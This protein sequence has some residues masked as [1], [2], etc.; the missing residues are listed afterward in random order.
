[1]DRKK[2]NQEEEDLLL[3]LLKEYEDRQLEEQPEGELLPSEDFCQR[4]EKMIEDPSSWRKHMREDRRKLRLIQTQ[5]VLALATMAMVLFLSV[6]QHVGVIRTSA[7]IPNF[8]LMQPDESDDTLVLRP[9]PDAEPIVSPVPKKDEALPEL[10]LG[11]LPSD[12]VYDSSFHPV[13]ENQRERYISQSGEA[14]IYSSI[15]YFTKEWSSYFSGEYTIEQILVGDRDV[16]K[17][18]GY[19]S[20]TYFW[21]EG[22]YL[23]ELYAYLVTEEEMEQVIEAVSLSAAGQ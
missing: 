4:M 7:S 19:D 12:F 22:D 6:L 11:Y 13:F 2:L 15:R 5:K 14:I 20:C 18:A 1:M 21:R 8:V 3:R 9:N 16:A 17:I 10:V 23:L